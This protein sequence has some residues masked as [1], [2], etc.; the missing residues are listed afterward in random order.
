MS[1]RR[2]ALASVI[3]ALSLAP[4]PSHA[5]PIALRGPTWGRVASFS[6]GTPELSAG[7]WLTERFGLAVEWRLPVAATGVSAATRWR[8][9]GDVRGWGVDLTL[10]GGVVVPLLDPA[11][12]VSITPSVAGRWRGQY[13][14]VAAVLVAP[15]VV[16][17]AP[18]T[19]VRLPLLAEAWIATH[20][21]SLSVG[22]QGSV[23]SVFVPGL[24]WSNA[25]QVSAWVGWDL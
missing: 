14:Q 4:L 19:L 3:V 5:D 20:I 6:A 21:A 24:S 2:A 18:D 22:V 10:A 1:V 11:V 7:A 15:T 23:G 9:V 8:L 16:R 17:I 25:V 12:A 13:L